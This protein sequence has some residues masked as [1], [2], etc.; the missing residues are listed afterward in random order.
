MKPN[1]S[2]KSDIKPLESDPFSFDDDSAFAFDDPIA[3]ELSIKDD[4]KT[5]LPESLQGSKDHFTFEDELGFN[6]DQPKPDSLIQ[7]DDKPADTI[8]PLKI[9]ECVCPKCKGKNEIELDLIP[10]D[11]LKIACST[12]NKKIQIIKESCACRAMRRSNE[13]NCS[14]CGR[15]LDR[16]YYCLSCGVIFPDYFVAIDP[17]DV[18]RKSQTEYFNNIWTSIADLKFSSATSQDSSKKITYDYTSSSKSDGT[19]IKK[20]FARK[21]VLSLVALVIAIALISTGVYAYNAYQLSKQYAE[22]YFKALYCM[23]TGIETNLGVC[24]ATRVEWEA[25]LQAGRNYIP[26]MSSRNEVK[27]SKLHGEI[28]NLL[29]KMADPPAK[30]V[31]ANTRL[32]EVNKIYT[33]TELIMQTPPVTVQD[34][35]KTAE[36][37]ASKMQKASQELKASIPNELKPELEIAKQKYRGMKDF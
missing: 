20:L 4:K 2:P 12:C 13:I 35:N 32:L 18:R 19:G 24:E 36:I 9:I 27:S 3:V 23:K 22:N 11:G 10:E 21:V 8:E 29:K 1:D 30:F 25:A 37:L 6:L 33:D 26:S 34:L 7:A 31:H 15:P 16:H 5:T 28:D 14:N 17:D